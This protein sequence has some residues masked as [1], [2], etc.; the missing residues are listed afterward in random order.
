MVYGW[1]ADEIDRLSLPRLFMYAYPPES[2]GDKPG[3]VTGLSAAEA[4]V[5]RR[6][7]QAARIRNEGS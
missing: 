6:Q 5:F 1:T 2:S 4:A 3:I 7:R